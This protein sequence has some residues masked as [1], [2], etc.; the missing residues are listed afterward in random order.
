MHPCL[1]A[2]GVVPATGMWILASPGKGMKDMPTYV[3]KANRCSCRVLVMIDENQIKE[4]KSYPLRL[5]V[6]YQPSAEE[7]VKMQQK[8]DL[9][10]TKRHVK[11]EEVLV[12]ESPRDPLTRAGLIASCQG[13][14]NYTVEFPN[15][16]IVS[17]V[18]FDRVWA[19][20]ASRKRSS[21]E[22][23]GSAD[24]GPL[25]VESVE[26]V[27]RHCGV[28]TPSSRCDGAMGS[29]QEHHRPHGDPALGDWASKWLETLQT[30]FGSVDT[31][32]FEKELLK[33]SVERTCK[34]LADMMAATPRLSD[35]RV[36][37]ALGK[38][39]ASERT[40]V[41]VRIL[42]ARDTDTLSTMFES[43]C[44]QQ[45]ASECLSRRARAFRV[46]KNL[47]YDAC[48]ASVALKTTS[49][50]RNSVARKVYAMGARSVAKRIQR[51]WRRSLQLKRAPSCIAPL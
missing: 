42:R 18:P 38:V 44:R 27:K 3:E 1:P 33:Q 26:R 47:G 4:L 28:V 19:L 48:A 49:A 50:W 32:K 15:G 51:W 7:K 36:L 43:M 10:Y 12:G 35:E 34:R 22:V 9:V 5:A 31:L 21:P 46:L 40:L 24:A 37:A 2:V 41:A 23:D 20:P 6:P 29:A 8:R 16:E 39:R 14:F 30:F 25:P 17:G 11:G 13:R 45:T